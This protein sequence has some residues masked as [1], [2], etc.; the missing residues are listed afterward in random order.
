M[1][2]IEPGDAKP[3]YVMTL[4]DPLIIRGVYVGDT[5]IDEQVVDI[6]IREELSDEEWE[7][8][9]YRYILEAAV[10]CSECGTANWVIIGTDPGDYRC[11]NCTSWL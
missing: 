11:I 4:V 6:R 8:P 7:G 5:P 9:A 3:P 1:I 2:D 10:K